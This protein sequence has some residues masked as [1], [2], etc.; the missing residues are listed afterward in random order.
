MPNRLRNRATRSSRRST[1]VKPYP[2]STGRQQQHDRVEGSLGPRD[3][4]QPPAPLK[5]WEVPPDER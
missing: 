5:W 3:D 1:P 2:V 4:E